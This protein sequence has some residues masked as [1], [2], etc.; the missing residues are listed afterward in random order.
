M[1][2]IGLCPRCGRGSLEHLRS[3]SYCWECN[4]SPEIDPTLNQYYAIEYPRA[5]KKGKPLEF[6]ST[7]IWQ[8]VSP[9]HRIL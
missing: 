6:G 9:F 3:Y 2:E 1:S 7:L 4:Y 5:R 8:S